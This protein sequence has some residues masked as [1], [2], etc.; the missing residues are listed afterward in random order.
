M[1]PEESTPNFLTPGRRRRAGFL[2][3]PAKYKGNTLPGP[4]S[5]AEDQPGKATC[6]Y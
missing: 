5:A 2:C 6:P 3:L 1:L 4:A